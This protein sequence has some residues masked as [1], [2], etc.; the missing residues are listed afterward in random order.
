[1]HCGLQLKAIGSHI[2][3]CA[4]FSS[5]A[6]V[7]AIGKI[8]FFYI[9]GVSIWK[10]TFQA[11]STAVLVHGTTTFV[12]THAK[13]TTTKNQKHCG[14]AFGNMRYVLALPK[15]L[16]P[17]RNYIKKIKSCW[18]FFEGHDKM[19]HEITLSS[20]QIFK[21]FYDIHNKV[22]TLTCLAALLIGAPYWSGA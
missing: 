17:T 2:I 9:G 13:Q 3:A 10:D 11:E 21:N 7:A 14:C 22:K 16:C 5:A 20:F 12:G 15:D 8:S 4:G 18:P 1:M 6:T 19:T